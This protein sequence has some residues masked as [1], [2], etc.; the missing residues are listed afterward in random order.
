MAA[1]DPQFTSL[2]IDPLS[3][4]NQRAPPVDNYDT[5]AG[6]YNINR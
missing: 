2:S 5:R 1:N 4:Q 3:N 6:T